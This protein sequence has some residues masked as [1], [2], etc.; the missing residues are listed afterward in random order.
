MNIINDIAKFKI[1]SYDKNERITRCKL[2][3][4]YRLVH[5]NNWTSGIYNHISVS[6]SL[7]SIL[8]FF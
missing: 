7:F 5:L 3:S 4:L 1:T 6:I 2:A 8:L